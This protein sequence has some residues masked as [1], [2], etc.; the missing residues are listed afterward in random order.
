ME[1]Q[2][3]GETNL[4]V[5]NTA[6][7]FA[8]TV[9]FPLMLNFKKFQRQS[10]YGNDDLQK[11]GEMSDEV[12]NIE[13]VNGLKAMSETCGDLL[14]AISST[15][16]LKGNKKELEELGN[17]I[18]YIEK[19]KLLFYEHSERFYRTEYSGGE[20]IEVLDRDYFEKVKKIVET[21]YINT[22]ILMT[23]N[24]LIF[25]DASDEFA[26]DEEILKSIKEEYIN[27]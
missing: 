25:S 20:V 18:R 9:L 3:R 23:R 10:N 2:E 14:G 13:R 19:V 26:S 4:R 6:K 12:R 1:Q 11:A 5:F 24:K 16:R 7:L 17:V 22:E 8:E 21:C 27:N 15:V